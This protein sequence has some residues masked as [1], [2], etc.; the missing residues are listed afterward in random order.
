MVSKAE[1]LLKAARE[2][3]N[4]AEETDKA[5]AETEKADARVQD[6]VAENKRAAAADEKIEGR[7]Q[8]RAASLTGEVDPDAM[9][10]V[11]GDGRDAKDYPDDDPDKYLGVPTYEHG[12]AATN[13]DNPYGT[14]Q[15]ERT[16]AEIERGRQLLEA[17]KSSRE[18]EA[19]K[20]GTRT[21]TVVTDADEDPKGEEGAK[22]AEAKATRK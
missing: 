4:I 14:R 17:K 22:K 21:R 8:A 3:A 19:P 15:S 2:R 18:R 5:K 9:G 16:R 6:Q 7:V 13:A 20:A 12:L 11:K 10:D 1:E